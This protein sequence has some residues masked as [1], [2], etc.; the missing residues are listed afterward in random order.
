VR[1]P[2]ASDSVFDSHPRTSSRTESNAEGSLRLPFAPISAALADVPPEP[3]WLFDGY[4]APGS[5]TLLAGQPKVG[6]TTM[7]FGLLAAL[8]EGVPF[9]ERSTRAAGALLLTE[10]RPA[11]LAE[12]QDRWMLRDDRTHVLMR[13]DAGATSFG[14]VV[15]QAVDYCDQLA[16]GLIVVDTFDKWAGFAGDSENSA[17]AVLAAVEPLLQAAANGP[18]VLLL[19][20]QR[21][22]G[23]RHGE[24]VRGSNALTGAVDIVLEL[25]R[26][27]AVPEA[28]RL[29]AVS[30][31]ATT[32][33]HLMFVATS[34]GFAARE[35]SDTRTEA[36]RERV[37]SVVCSSPATTEV[38]AKA[39][40]MAKSTASRHLKDLLRSNA[41][42]R[43]GK[44][45]KG[46]EYMWIRSTEPDSLV[47]E[48]NRMPTADRPE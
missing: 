25:E 45:V 13:H 26:E 39:A 37:L 22:S 6:K 31:F 24:A 2:L 1:S 19:T 8:Q 14:E 46:D 3:E 10:E 7:V 41:V 4:V 33:D 29:R 21:K 36:Q 47:D 48:S 32:P 43:S 23:G 18:A 16:L 5:L 12:K 20:H 42:T 44:G 35:V 28:R 30:R 17:G 15:E 9:L 34:D 27:G 40:G 38:I 11:T